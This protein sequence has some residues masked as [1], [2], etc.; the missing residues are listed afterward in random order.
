MGNVDSNGQTKT[1]RRASN[2][3]GLS[4]ED[5]FR[6][7][8]VVSFIALSLIGLG[9]M[10]YMS[11]LQAKRFQSEAATLAVTRWSG[12][13]EVGIEQLIAP[14]Q[15]ESEEIVPAILESNRLVP[16][17]QLPEHLGKSEIAF[18]TS[19]SGDP[20]W[21][22]NKHPLL[23]NNTA[24]ILAEREYPE[25]KI[26]REAFV[27]QRWL[28][29][30]LLAILIIACT[31]FFSF[32]K[33]YIFKPLHLLRDALLSRRMTEAARVK[34]L[35][36][37]KVTIERLE[38]H[39]R[40]PLEQ[41]EGDE[42]GQIAFI[43]ED[44]DRRQKSMRDSWLKSFNT[45]NEPIA[46]FGQNARLKHINEAMEQFLDEIGL[47]P[48]LVRN[49]PAS[50]FLN[51]YL[52]LEEESSAKLCKVLSQKL[53][54]VQA[55][56]CTVELPEGKRTF[57]YSV[58]TIINHG[59]RFAVFSLIREQILGQNH[60]F[61]DVILEQANSQ[62]KVIHR[63]QQSAREMSDQKA[64]TVLHLCET[65]VDNIH[66]LLE[67]SNASNPS[68]AT[69]KV[70]FNV[71]HFFREMQESIEG[72]LKISVEMEKSLPTF[73]VGD[74][75]HLRQF[76]K[77]IFQSFHETNSVE[78]ILMNIGYNTSEKKLI[79]SVL[80]PDGNPVLRDPS[81]Q[82]YLAHYSPFLSLS[83]F[84]DEDLHADEFIR[85]Q[86]VAQAGINR[87]ET[88]ELDLSNRQLPKSLI[89]VSDEILPGEAREVLE[90]SQHVNC[91]W[92]TPGEALERKFSNSGEC[93]LLFITNTQKLKDKAIQKVINHARGSSVP[94][95]LLS[96]QPRRGESLTA[97]RLG[98]V[99]YLTLPFEHD[100]LHKLLIL[101]MNKSV[102]ESIGKL[103]LITKH[104][105]RDLVPS[106][107]KVLLGNISK[108]HQKEALILLNTL[109]NLGFRVQET[110]TVHSFFELL[111]KGTFE[112]IVC[113]S[114]LSTGLKR[115]IQI[116]SRDV[117][118]VLFGSCSLDEPGRS[119]E[120]RSAAPL[121]SWI[122]IADVSNQQEV[123]D[124]LHAAQEY[125][126]RFS[127]IPE[128][129]SDEGENP[130]DNL[131]LAI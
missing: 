91:E 60:N 7:T 24:L 52:Q 108:Q 119:D 76:L 124:A 87:I 86:I 56:A 81:L 90:S 104:T 5:R 71:F 131:E 117:P 55:A 20:L 3:L 128:E 19:S 29:T 121:A 57:R 35:H 25:L 105:V 106:L 15:Q 54:K 64:D 12:A 61:E 89:I 83:S 9:S 22:I 37:S 18:T 41:F 47:D 70:E 42:F 30:A 82:L 95:V 129:E 102:R 44:E 80:S 4:V 32:G 59:E 39:S 116:S 122:T 67:I 49:L 110:S 79:I 103:G 113:P 28:A 100:E 84:P 97:L 107:G 40:F 114:G 85:V 72:A 77:G 94:S 112:Y 51:S 68:L 98:F 36:N 62:L 46:V 17:S 21:V 31:V 65:L 63:L 92:L 126:K 74:P 93:M 111:H 11:D 16:R 43:L 69:H 1:Q 118:C 26:A 2:Q 115:R 99:T 88:L 50:A 14:K 101:T 96:Q 78:S 13:F 48:D 58:S 73:I 8:I 75:T 123:K 27:F 33:Y 45:I 66:S 34:Q 6:F 130:N 125:E 120:N 127:D 109:T 23:D 38:E 53:P 10:F